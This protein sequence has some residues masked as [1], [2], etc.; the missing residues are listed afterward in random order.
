MAIS[1]LEDSPEGHK[2]WDYWVHGKGAA[3]IGW[4]NPDD[5]DRCLL[6]LEKYTPTGA[7]GLC[8]EMHI[9]A[10]GMT[11]TEHAK[12]LGKHAG[13]HGSAGAHVAAETDGKA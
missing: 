11:T 10:T 1:G 6:E 4:G 8:A 7:H 2:L 3:K 9:A 12:L 5:Y 13:K